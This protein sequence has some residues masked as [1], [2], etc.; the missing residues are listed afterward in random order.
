MANQF[1]NYLLTINNP[2][3]EDSEFAEYIKALRYVKYFIFQREAGEEKGTPH[4]QLYI[5]FTQG[6]TF[7]TMKRNFPT[8]HIE[9]RKGTKTQAREYCSKKETRIGEVYEYG[10]FAEERERSDWTDILAMIAEGATN[11]EI[12][13]AYPSQFLRYYKAI[14]DNREMF[15][16]EKYGKMRRIDL[17]VTYIFGSA[18]VG[19][20]SYV[21]DTFGDDHV[22]RMTDYGSSHN[23]ERFDGYSGHD[24]LLFDEFRSQIAMSSMLNYLDIYPLQ[25]PARFHNKTACYT[26]V[27]IVSNIPLSAQYP[28][29]QRENPTTWEAFLRR[30]HEVY[31]FNESKTVPLPRNKWTATDLS[32]LK[33]LTAQQTKMLPF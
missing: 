5:E 18:G 29:I 30:F 15:I 32:L 14:E 23:I 11:K 33:P 4:I 24:V 8:A 22:F 20:T 12:R 13:E 21:L 9:S 1:R 28:N 7:D 17:K 26:K 6:V 10:E 3:K 27:F 19:K 16:A 25:L 2:E 31:N